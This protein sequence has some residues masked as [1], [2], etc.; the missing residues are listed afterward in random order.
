MEMVLSLRREYHLELTTIINIIKY[1]LGIHIWK[2]KTCSL[3][4]ENIILN[5][6]N[7]TSY[8]GMVL[9]PA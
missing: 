2:N 7:V 8:M 3:A 1:A 5:T 4:G 6:L 9:S